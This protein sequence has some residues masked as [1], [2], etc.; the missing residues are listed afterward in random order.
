MDKNILQVAIRHWKKGRLIFGNLLLQHVMFLGVDK[1]KVEI[2][3][4]KVHKVQ[5][6]MY[7]QEM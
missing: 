5:L 3:L 7:Y 2:V 6:E 1:A 4:V